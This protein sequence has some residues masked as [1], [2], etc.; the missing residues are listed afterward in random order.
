AS[1]SYLFSESYGR[2]TRIDAAQ[3]VDLD[4]TTLKDSPTTPSGTVEATIAGDYVAY[5][6]D[7]GAVFTGTL[8]G[9]EVTQVDPSASADGPQYTST[10]IGLDDEGVLYS[11]SPADRAVLR[12]DIAA[13]RV[14]GSDPVAGS[15]DAEVDV[16]S[17]GDT[18]YLVDPSEGLVWIRDLEEPVAVELTGAVA[19]ARASAHADALYLADEAGLVRLGADGAAPTRV[20]G[21]QARD[22]G[23]PARP[24]HFGGQTYAAWLRADGGVLW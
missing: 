6:T 10:A 8:A 3:P 4:A 22:F 7:S 11:Y 15:V 13:A 23:T 2:V 21:G 5:R 24:T 14:L 9:G 20:V 18:W 12:Y 16:V 1:G 17:A 19:I